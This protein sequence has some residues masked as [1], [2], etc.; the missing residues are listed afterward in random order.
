MMND[1]TESKD[2]ENQTEQTEVV[3]ET[4]EETTES[5]EVDAGLSADAKTKEDSEKK[6]KGYKG[7]WLRTQAEMDKLRLE[8]EMLKTANKP[9]EKHEEKL[10]K[11][12]RD[13]FESVEEYTEALTDFKLK[14]YQAAQKTASEKQKQEMSLK[15]KQQA[16]DARLESFQKETKDFDEVIENFIDEHGDIKFSAAMN[17]LIVESDLG[18][19]LIYE[20]AKDKAFLD[21]VNGMSA[22]AA[23]KEIGKLEDKILAKKQETKPK[24]K[25]SAPVKPLTG[26]SAVI[27]KNLF[28]D[29]LSP[30]EYR[31]LKMELAQKRA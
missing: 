24:T 27:K 22:Y 23:A 30:A 20:L 18:P 13:D 14:E 8:I 15:E 26:G 2:L 7:K 21:K 5:T 28:D 31:K 16:H 19:Q 11:P 1:S 3:E 29:S 12:K 4:T 6:I 10:E 17:E 25:A 9:V